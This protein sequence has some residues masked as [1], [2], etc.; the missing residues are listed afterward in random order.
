MAKS[1]KISVIR[2]RLKTISKLT[3]D[4]IS[5]GV[6]EGNGL[7]QDVVYEEVLGL[8]NDIS[9][10]VKSSHDSTKQSMEDEAGLKA[11]RVI[12]ARHNGNITEAFKELEVSRTYQDVSKQKSKLSPTDTLK[13]DDLTSESSGLEY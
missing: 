5:F 12:L 2:D 9:K 13:D 6:L 1:I 8:L 3:Q 11:W 4:D 10:Q 7:E